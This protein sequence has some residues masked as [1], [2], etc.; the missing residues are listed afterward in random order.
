M[1]AFVLDDFGAEPRV[2]DRPEPEPGE[3]E[4][5]VRVNASSV[6]PIDNAIAGGLLRQMADYEFPVI[7]G[8]DFAGVVDQV[9]GGVDFS[10]GEEVFG[11]V[12]PAAA[13]IHNG[14]WADLIRVPAESNVAK[15]PSG[16]DFATAGATGLAGMTA[17]A[18]VNA[19][20]LQDGEPVLI[21]GATGGLG[22]FAV[23][24]AK[25]AGAHV[26]APGF[27]EDEGYLV[28]LGAD[29]VIR[30]DDDVTAA[31]RELESGGVAALLDFVSHTPEELDGYAA[32]LAEGGRVASALNAAGDG[33][34]RYN[35]GPTG[36][37]AELEQLARLLDN[38]KLRVPIQRSYPLEEAGAALTDLPGTHTQGKLGVTVAS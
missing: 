17:L 5:V 4:L 22:T 20:A 14:A 9:G 7:L 3:G 31:A 8:R 23:Q 35:V 16:V 34:G 33:P 27:P 18:A 28:D 19:V 11:K 12:L 30:R 15:K 2:R 26:I 13:T 1:R 25:H 36:E 21:V 6:N 29:H 24:L 38:G 32:A 10:E 37:R